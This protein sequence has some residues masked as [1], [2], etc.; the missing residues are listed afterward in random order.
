[1]SSPIK[2]ATVN[3]GA[4]NSRAVTVHILGCGMG[5]NICSPL[6]RTAVHRCGK[7]IVNNQWHTVVMSGLCPTL[8]IKNNQCRVCN[9]LTKDA[10]CIWSE[11]IV[12]FLVSCIWR[13]K[14]A[15]HTH[16]FKGDS[17]QVKGSAINGGKRNKVISGLS[18]VKDGKEACCLTRRSQHCSSTALKSANL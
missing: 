6:K 12:N 13:D 18:N 15:L 2:V 1:M 8:N 3:N 16:L 5:H 9:S 17:K 11:C 10:L 14:R 4:A 7:R